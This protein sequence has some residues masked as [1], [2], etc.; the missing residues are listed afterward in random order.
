MD[1]RSFIFYFIILIIDGLRRAKNGINNLCTAYSKRPEI[2]A[3]IKVCLSNIQLQLDKYNRVLPTENM[4]KNRRS[5]PGGKDHNDNTKSDQYNLNNP[6]PSS[7]T[8]P[9]LE[10]QEITASIITPVVNTRS[11]EKFPLSSINE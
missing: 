5:I 3:D 4:G 6:L 11:N 7:N 8:I 9:S 10:R 1:Y 2:L